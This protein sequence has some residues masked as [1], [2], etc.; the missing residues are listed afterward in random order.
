MALGPVAQTR[1]WSW[2]NGESVVLEVVD[3]AGLFWIVKRHHQEW[4]YRRE[5][6]A[7][8]DWAPVMGAGRVPTVRAWDDATRT[9]VM[10]R[11]PG[12]VGAV[13]TADGHRQAGQ[14][15]ARFHALGP[16]GEI[17][18]YATTM[19]SQL[20]DWLRR[21]PEVLAADE[22]SF[23]RNR[24]DALS[25]LPAPVT[26]PTH[27]DYQPRNWLLDDAGALRVFDFG[28]AKVDMFLRD[29]ERMW[30]AQWTDQPHLRQAFF[31]GYGRELDPHE[32]SL[33]TVRGAYQAASTILWAREH[34][35][36]DFE[37]HGRRMLDRLRRERT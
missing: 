28:R 14:L 1:D 13:D 21:V 12:V 7:L 18:D 31:A 27:N 32:V 17:E 3:A 8:L 20:D 10:T 24:I 11:L 15:I 30:F 33:I 2:R 23:V 37:R 9:L 4:A 25:S 26:A 34:A 35:D 6:P 36:P 22:I 19:H 29:F 5:L 16:A